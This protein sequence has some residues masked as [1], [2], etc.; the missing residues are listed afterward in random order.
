VGCALR[1]THLADAAEPDGDHTEFVLAACSIDAAQSIELLHKAYRAFGDELLAKLHPASDQSAIRAA[2]PSKL[3]YS[4]RT[5]TELLPSARLMLYTYSVVPYE[6][7]AAGVPPVFVR[8][9]SRIDLDQLD[10][11]PAIRWVARTPEEL[12]AVS[13]QIDSLPDRAAWKRRAAEVV[14][15]ALA[16]VTPDCIEQFLN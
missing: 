13:A 14:R 6:A 2:L 9:D 12:R 16:P 5:L 1:H 4:D 11:S 10:P 15:A 7:L 3:R 8:S